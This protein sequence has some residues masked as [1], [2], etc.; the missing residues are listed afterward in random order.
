MLVAMS[1]NRIRISKSATVRLS[2]L[3]GGQA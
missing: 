2:I 1:F 3:R